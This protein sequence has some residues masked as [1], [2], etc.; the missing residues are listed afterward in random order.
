MPSSVDADS[1][2]GRDDEVR[3]DR[4]CEPRRDVERAACPE[5][6]VRDGRD[7]LARGQARA[8]RRAGQR[9]V[10]RDDLDHPVAGLQPVADRDPVAEGAGD[11]LDDSEAEQGPCPGEQRL[12]VAGADALVDRAAEHPRQ[13]RLREHPDDPEGHPEQERPDLVAPDPEQEPGRRAHVGAARIGEGKLLHRRASVCGG[14]EKSAM[15]SAWP[16]GTPSR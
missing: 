1:R 11:R 2:I 7:D 16:S 12:G 9:C 13:Q 10:V 3:G 4:A 15:M 5:R 6:V 14:P 8:N